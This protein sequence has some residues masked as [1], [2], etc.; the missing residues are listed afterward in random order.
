MIFGSIQDSKNI[1]GYKLADT[2]DDEIKKIC[3]DGLATAKR[4]VKE[5]RDVLDFIAKELMIKENIERAEFEEILK[6]F[7]IALKKKEEEI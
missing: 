2:V 7:D 3:E 4:I 6:K 5:K 1:I